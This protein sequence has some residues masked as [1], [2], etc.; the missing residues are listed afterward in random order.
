MEYG[1]PKCNP[2]NFDLYLMIMGGDQYEL[3]QDSSQMNLAFM[4]L[5]SHYKFMGIMVIVIFAVYAV[6]VAFFFLTMTI[7]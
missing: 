1:L 7:L 4:N 2:G 6:F 5:K 3:A